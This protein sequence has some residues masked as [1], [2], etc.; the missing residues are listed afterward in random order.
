MA[1]RPLVD[2]GQ[3][4]AE[5]VSSSSR[6]PSLFR[7]SIHQRRNQRETGR[8]LEALHQYYQDE[9]T[10]KLHYLAQWAPRAVYLIGGLWDW[11]LRHPLLPE[12][13]QY[14]QERRAD[15]D[16]FHTCFVS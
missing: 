12:L 7:E 14:G 10:R 6:F 11:L 2:G 15:S 8:Y 5:V 4:P 13:L 1:W 3:T 16:F 9:G